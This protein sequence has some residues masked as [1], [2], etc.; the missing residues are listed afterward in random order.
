[1]KLRLF[2]LFLA[3]LSLVGLSCDD[4]PNFEQQMEIDRAI[5]E[6]F[7]AT[8]NLDGYFLSTGVYVHLTHEGTGTET[9]GPLDNILIELAGSFLDGT[10]FWSNSVPEPWNMQNFIEG[11]QQGLQEFK[12]E[13]R[14]RIICPSRLAYGTTGQGDIEPNTVIQFEI[15]YVEIQ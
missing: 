3:G 4:T 6:E 10:E 1:M 13:S 9:V 11:V 2:Y 15:K 7:V 14:G 5:I 8:N 12:N